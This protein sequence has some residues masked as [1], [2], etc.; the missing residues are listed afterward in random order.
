M[1]QSTA[2]ADELAGI[3]KEVFGGEP[4]LDRDLAE[5]G[6]QSVK[7]IEIVLRVQDRLAVTLSLDSLLVPTTLRALADEIDRVREATA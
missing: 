5:L 1:G 2:T 6:I 4:D 3:W 7:L